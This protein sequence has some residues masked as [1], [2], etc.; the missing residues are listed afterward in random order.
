MEIIAL[1]RSAYDLALK[2]QE[3]AVEDLRQGA[4]VECLFYGSHEPVVTVGPKAKAEEYQQWTGS[5]FRT[6][7][8]GRATYHGPGQLICYPILDLRF[9]REKV[10]KK[11]LHSYIR[12]L[13]NCVIESLLQIDVTATPSASVTDSARD[14]SDLDP[15]DSKDKIKTGVWVAGQKVAS[16]GI[17]VRN[18]IT[19][20]GVAINLWEDPLAF[21]GLRPC[22]F[23]AEVMTNVESILQ[24]RRL[25]AEKI[26]QQLELVQEQILKTLL[27]ALR[28]KR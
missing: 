4:G 13:E 14:D 9:E 27:N 19:Y 5:I 23:S 17:A 1:G 11:D 12:C 6:S 26:R 22:G 10:N 21:R 25:P 18:W 8:G 2:V 28:L 16:I 24:R 7:R 20:H 15:L 3:K